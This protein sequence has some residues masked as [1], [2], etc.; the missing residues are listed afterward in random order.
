M[1]LLPITRI[2]GVENPSAVSL[3]FQLCSLR[4]PDNIARSAFQNPITCYKA[5]NPIN[6]VDDFIIK[7]SPINGAGIKMGD[8][9][10]HCRTHVS[11]DSSSDTRSAR[12]PTPVIEDK[13]TT[14]D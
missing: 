14:S 10:S 13:T 1:Q 7:H 4:N 12:R 8:A 11:A 2:H 5:E 3:I 6:N 9:C